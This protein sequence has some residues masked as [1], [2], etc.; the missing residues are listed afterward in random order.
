[1]Y[2]AKHL[3]E[4]LLLFS[5]WLNS[6][7][8]HLTD[9][10]I[11]RTWYSLSETGDVLCTAT[12]KKNWLIYSSRNRLWLTSLSRLVSEQQIRQYHLL[13]FC[14]QGSPALRTYQEKLTKTNE[15]K[16]KLVNAK[17]NVVKQ[18]NI[19]ILIKSGAR[20]NSFLTYWASF[21]TVRQHVNTTSGES[22][23]NKNKGNNMKSTSSSL[24]TTESVPW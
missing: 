4:D 17:H 21:A 2:F 1:M 12:S 3:W 8:S 20:A 16:Q 15:S 22:K 7:I 6:Q 11:S 19:F 14:L 10:L 9:V 18:S 23:N 24:K 13:M 5:N